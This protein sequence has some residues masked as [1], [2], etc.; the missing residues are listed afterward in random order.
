MH[1]GADTSDP[2]TYTIALGD[3]VYGAKLT[4]AEDGSVT[5]LIDRAM[6]RVADSSVV[7]GSTS[8]SGTHR[9]NISVAGIKRAA[10]AAVLGNLICSSYPN[11][12]SLA[13]YR[14][15]L[16]ASVSHNSDS[17][18]IYDPEFATATV[19]EFKAAKGD[20]QLVYEFATP[21]EIQL[22]PVTIAAIA[23]QTN[24][25]WANTGDVSVEYAVDVKTYI[26]QKIAAA[27]AALS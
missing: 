5:A 10:A 2:T 9:Y 24:N 1:S 26:D 12:T 21:I 27:V 11:T 3:T 23:G 7:I 16:G 13:T 19:E 18:F 17:I 15:T 25:V 20:V 14:V 6:V 8:V 22:D 4:I